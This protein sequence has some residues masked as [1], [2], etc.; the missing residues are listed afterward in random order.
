MK[1]NT[2][3]G[4]RRMCAQRDQ[5]WMTVSGA[6]E[7]NLQNITASIPKD[8]VTV[9]TGLSG[10]GKSSL[11]LDVLYAE[12]QRRYM[13][14]LSA[15]VRQFLGMPHKPDVDRIDG[16][17]P[18]IA[19]DQKTVTSNP[20]STVGT[21]TEIHDY[22]RVL[23]ARIGVMHCPETGEPVRECSP[24][25]IVHKI[26]EYWPELFVYVAA[27][28]VRERK[29]THE[30]LISSLFHKG[31]TRFM[32]DG[33]RYRFTSADDIQALHLHKNKAHTI[34]VLLDA[35]EVVPQE[36]SRL[37][38][39]VEQSC[40]LADGLCRIIVGDTSYYFSTQR[41]SITTGRSF[42]QLEP[43][44][45][46]FNSPIGACNRCHG[47][48]TL[49][50][51][52]EQEVS[53]CP[54]C[55]GKRLH[56][57][58]LSVTVGGKNIDEVGR[59]SIRDAKQFFDHLELDREQSQIAERLI[60]EIQHRLRFLCNVG[61]DYLSVHRDARTLS[62]GESQRIRLARQ[63]GSG[64]SGVLYVLDEPSIGL[65][66]RDNKKLIRTLQ[67]L[68]DLGNTVLVVE[69][70]DETIRSADYVIDLGPGA[71]RHG[72]QV[73]AS[74]TP[75]KMMRNSSS[76]T[77]QY[78]SG[79]KY[80]TR[81]QPI[82]SPQGY[83]TVH[84]ADTHNLRHVQVDFPVGVLCGVSGVSGSGKSSLV[85]HELIPA[86]QRS[87]ISPQRKLENDK[88]SG[89]EHVDNV[90]VINQ[91]P[92]GRTPRSN[93]ATYLGIF[94]DIRSLF[95]RLP[96]SQARGYAAGRFSFNVRGGRCEKCSGDGVLTVTLHFLPDVTLTCD[97]C[98]GKRYHEDT[99]E[100]TYRNTTIADIL[101]MTVEEVCEFFQHHKRIYKRLKLMWDV[102]LGYVKL[103]QSSTTLS[104]GEAQRIKLVNELAKRG[105]RTVYVLDEPTTGLHAD[106]VKR[107]IA[108]LQRLVDKGNSVYV[109]EH[110]VDVLK[111]AD[112]LIDLGPEGGDNGGT[113]VARGTPSQ[114]AATHDSHT[115]AVLRQY[116]DKRQRG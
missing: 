74:G 67:E 6:R 25:E 60:Q 84:N 87:I 72:G 59:L 70:D 91:T 23:F 53:Q 62:G 17:C 109:I 30:Q 44:M 94:D 76:L 82:R 102:G 33:N 27:P 79:E 61:L 105:S 56:E 89:L 46:S 99:L 71:G 1:E 9:V 88:V 54:V 96:E 68:R 90:V 35:V 43:R 48:G 31:Y 116:T 69:H 2:E 26:E 95:A 52:Y 39:S 106:D 55:H 83:L 19:I 81:Y 32:I 22:L 24:I 107:L 98:N 103:G 16:L 38:E 12:G 45:F 97:R 108:V 10:S 20:R 8:S 112:Y 36:R 50:D 111:V 77:G 64:L 18:A 113:L 14:S 7:H 42:P 85:M 49:Y 110:N 86:L 115:G 3:R 78:L 66:Q 65:H 15:Y 4:N 41:M 57:L 21:V 92:I 11:A 100:I 51:R 75:Q 58:P 101:D 34:D 63:L 40:Y 47:I 37:R 114:V 104:G 28:I 29:G 73:V 93:P 13:E 80:I 5:N